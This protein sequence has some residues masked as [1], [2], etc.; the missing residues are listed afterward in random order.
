[1]ERYFKSKAYA[2][3]IIQ[4]REF[5]NSRTVLDGKARNLQEQGKGKQPNRSTS[6]TKEEEEVLWQNGQPRGGTPRAL[7]NTMWLLLTPHIGLGG[8]QEHHQIKVEYFTLQRDD[9]D[10]YF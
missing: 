1:M 10:T 2:K 4:D 5:L 7:L 6:L 3:S 9:N 8:R